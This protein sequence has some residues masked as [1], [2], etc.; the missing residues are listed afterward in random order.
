MKDITKI[1]FDENLKTVLFVIRDKGGCGYYRCLQ[2]AMYLRRFKMMNT[3]TDV[4]FTTK[5][6]IEQAD[7]VV[8]QEIGST[9][10]L[11]SFRYAKKLGKAV[12]V[13]VD[14]LL[15]MVSP[16][17]PGYAAWNPST[18]YIER[19][20]EKMRQADAM[21]VSTPQLAR[22]YEPYN[23]NM[24][25]MPNFLSQQQWDQSTVRKNDGIIRIGWAGGNSHFDDLKMVVPVLKKIV[26][27]YDGKV[28]FE[29]MGM[30][31]KEL[32]GIFS[33]FD[34]FTHECK[35][36]DYSGQIVMHP[37]QP[38]DQ[39]PVVLATHGWDIAIAPIVN[40]AF[41]CAKS[42]LKLKEYSAM[43]FS[44]VASR[45]TPYIEAQQNGCNVFLAETFK[46]WY[47]S[48]KQLIDDEML[49]QSM[50]EDNKK[51]AEGNWIEEN[52]KRYSEVYHKIIESNS[53]KK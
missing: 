37:G 23:E 41:N 43:G 12:V 16:R 28:R 24:Y 33:E 3:I 10:S 36:C 7:L 31:E 39:Y 30:L 48:L 53:H 18:L 1:P 20:V 42:D 8:F 17:N 29:I 46:E 32:K 11:D 22:D 51:W 50:I 15:H 35:K 27:E 9:A 38:L 14:D 4:K 25:V 49:R 47:N 40:N 6:H 2:P 45:V 21:T 5:E 44:I 34:H 26:K 19:A 52:I 13:E